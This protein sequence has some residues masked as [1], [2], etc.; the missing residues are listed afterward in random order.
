MKAR[1]DAALAA[2]AAQAST[3]HCDKLGPS[4]GIVTADRV[5]GVPMAAI[6]KIA[7]GLGR[8][9]DLAAALW[10]TR[11]YEGR[12]L[13]C[14]IDDPALVTAAQMDAWRAD[15]DNWAVTDTACFK[16]FDRVPGAAA[17]IEEETLEKR[18]G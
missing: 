8:D 18:V 1:V 14:L 15:F 11:V 3:A 4:F 10:T 9:H 16:L 12:M 6:Q 13:A 2:L 17:M 7:K 5:I